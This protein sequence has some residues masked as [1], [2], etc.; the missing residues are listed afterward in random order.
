MSTDW[1]PPHESGQWNSAQFFAEHRP[2]KNST[3]VF[4]LPIEL[5]HLLRQ[6]TGVE[7]KGP[8]AA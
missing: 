2:L 7:P 4:P 5:L 3:I 1:I 6:I 8:A